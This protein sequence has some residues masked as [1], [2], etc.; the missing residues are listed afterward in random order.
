[1]ALPYPILSCMSRPRYAALRRAASRSGG[2]AARRRVRHQRRGHG[3]AAGGGA[4]EGRGKVPFELPILASGAMYVVGSSTSPMQS[5]RQV[6]ILHTTP[7][8]PLILYHAAS[9]AQ[10]V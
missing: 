7:L 6:R 10:T 8:L 4:R 3:M 5:M 1:M 9:M 2:A